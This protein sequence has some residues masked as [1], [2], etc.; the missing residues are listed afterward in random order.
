MQ[1]FRVLKLKIIK[2][3]DK[4]E[5]VFS[6]PGVVEID[7]RRPEM[8]DEESIN[9]YSCAGEVE[10]DSDNQTSAVFIALIKLVGSICLSLVSL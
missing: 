6:Y 4:R 9:V 10:P 7:V 2:G 5:T 8:A 3:G 1:R